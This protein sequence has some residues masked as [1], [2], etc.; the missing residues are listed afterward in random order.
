[1]LII[2]M[3]STPTL[4]LKLYSRNVAEWVMMFITSTVTEME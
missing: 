3:L 1:M 2:A 4:K